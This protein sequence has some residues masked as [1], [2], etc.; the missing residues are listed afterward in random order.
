MHE[1]FIGI[2]LGTTYL[3]GAVLNLHDM[4]LNHVARLPF[5]DFI[6][7]LPPSHKEV[8]AREVVDATRQLILS[9]LTHAANCRGIVICSQMHGLVL[10]DAQGH[11][12]SNIIT[13]QDQRTNEPYT[14]GTG[15][16]YDMLCTMVSDSDRMALGNDLWASRPLSILY[17]LY[18][19]QD[20]PA[21]TTV[22]PVSLPDYVLADLCEVTPVTEATNAAAT[23]AFNL[24]TNNW[25]NTLITRAGLDGL[26]WCPIVPHGAPI[27]ELK[28][29]GSSIP[30]YTPFGDHQCALLG[31]FLQPDELSINVSTGSQVSILSDHLGSALDYQTRPFFD[32][33]YLRAVIHIP[34]GR[35]LNA[36]I[37]LLSELAEQQCVHIP[38]PWAYINT[39]TGGH[40]HSNLRVNLAF[41]PSSCGDVGSIA[42]MREEN[43][44]IADIFMAAYESM[45]DNYIQCARR[46]AFGSDYKRLV[47][48]GGLVHRADGLSAIIKRK[49]GL[50]YRFPPS[51][52]DTLL[53]LLVMAL[54]FSGKSPSV[55]AALSS[56]SDAYSAQPHASEA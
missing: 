42:N 27:G 30:C 28:I 17:W 20:I 44:T 12:L 39:V 23:G 3:K 7:N 2:D 51:N 40:E 53:G 22:M 52:E 13:W 36:L 34:A 49:F 45:A 9:L 46:I 6:P 1:T 37:R 21:H 31:S 8:D 15:T 4:K 38:D 56:V 25:H 29:S 41:F 47:L 32:N 19:H 43:M 26:S 16:Y 11:A 33:Q 24:H 50:P 14:S 5:P 10:C 48:S 18:A 55:Q 54:V 35:A